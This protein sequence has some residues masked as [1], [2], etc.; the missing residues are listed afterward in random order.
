MALFLDY[1]II[2]H[3]L[4]V[5]LAQVISQ[6][7]SFFFFLLKPPSKHQLS[8][9]KRYFYFYQHQLAFNFVYFFCILYDQ[10]NIYVPFCVSLPLFYI[11]SVISFCFCP[12]QHFVYSNF[13]FS[14]FLSFQISINILKLACHFLS[15]F[16]ALS[17][18]QPTNQPSKKTKKKKK[19]LLGF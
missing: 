13:L 18:N 3:C 15:L 14:L 16:L 2:C 12:K 11:I 5:F 7:C 1:L 6:I 10:K 8:L 9:R 4:F 19:K 17:P